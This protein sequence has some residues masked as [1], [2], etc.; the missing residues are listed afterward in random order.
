M[1]KPQR[2]IT[3]KEVAIDPSDPLQNTEISVDAPVSR[4]EHYRL[5]GSVEEMR[6]MM[7]QF[8]D[9][10]AAFREQQK[11]LEKQRQMEEDAVEARRVQDDDVQEDEVEE[12][13]EEDLEKQKEIALLKSLMQKYGAEFTTHSSQKIDG[14]THST[15]IRMSKDKSEGPTASKETD[16]VLTKEDI[17][18][19]V[20]EENQHKA[21]EGTANEILTSTVKK[22]LERITQSPFSPEI[23]MTPSPKKFHQPSFEGYTG[24]GDPGVHL[25]QYQQKMTL[26]SDNEAFLCKLFPASLKGQA[27]TWFYSLKKNSIKS[28]NDLKTCFVNQYIH[29]VDKE[30]GLESLMTIKQEPKESLKDYVARFKK[31][32]NRV[33]SAQENQKMTVFALKQGLRIGE[34][35]HRRFVRKNPP[36]IADAYRILQKEVDA[37]EEMKATMH[38]QNRLQNPVKEEK[39]AEEQRNNKKARF[40]KPNEFNPN[41]NNYS[42]YNSKVHATDPGQTQIKQVYGAA[43]AT[44]K[45]KEREGRR[46]R[47]VKPGEKVLTKRYEDIFD[48]IKDEPYL[49]YPKRPYTD[50]PAAHFCK[51][52]G[53]RC[54][55]TENCWHLTDEIQRLVKQGMLAHL[56]AEDQG[57]EDEQQVITLPQPPNPM[58][59]INM[60]I[61]GKRVGTKNERR[62]G[63]RQI[64]LVNQSMNFQEV[65]Q[66]APPRPADDDMSAIW[67]SA[68]DTKRLAS[69]HWDALVVTMVIANNYIK[70]TLVDGGSST[71][72]MSWSCFEALGFTD[73]DL[74]PARFSLFAFNDTITQSLGDITLP[75]V[76]GPVTKMI[77]FVVADFNSSYNVILGRGWIHEMKAVP[78]TYH[79]VI[80]FP[81]DKGL[82]ELRGNQ[83][84]SQKCME[85]ATRNVSNIGNTPKMEDVQQGKRPIV[86]EELVDLSKERKKA[87][88]HYSKEKENFISGSKEGAS[89][90]P[91]VN[92][93]AVAAPVT[94]ITLVGDQNQIEKND[95]SARTVEEKTSEAVEAIQLGSPGENKVTYIGTA[96]PQE[97]KDK[98]VKVLKDNV[99]SFAFSMNE[100]DGIPEYFAC[101]KLDLIQGSKPVKQRPRRL[102]PKLSSGVL[103]EIHRL[104]QAG[105]IR[106]VQ[107]SDWL[108]NMVVVPKKNGKLRVC[109]D[110]TDLNKAC[111]KDDYIMP[112][113][114]DLV[115]RTAGFELLSFM[116]GYAGYNQ[117]PMRESDEV[118]TS[119]IT[120]IG[121]FCYKRMP[122]GLKNAGATYQKLVDTMFRDRIQKNMEV[123]IDDM[124]VKSVTEDEHITDLQET[125]KTLKQYGMKLNPEKCA[126]GVSSGKFLGFL[127]SKR[128]IEACPTQIRALVE[129]PSPR[130]KKQVQKLVGMLNAL[131]RFISKSSDRCRPIF[132]LLKAQVQF[133]WSD[134][135][136]EAFQQLKQYL[137]SVPILSKAEDGEEL[138]L[139]LAVTDVAISSVL[140]RLHEGVEK[141]VYFLSKTLLDAE[142]RYSHLEK[143]AL[144]LVYS[145]QRLRPYFQ[146]CKITVVTSFPL[147]NIIERADKSS[148]MEKWAAI[149]A[150]HSLHYKPRTAIKAQAIADFLVDFPVDDQFWKEDPEVL[151]TAEE[152]EQMPDPTDPI[153]GWRLFTDGS[154]GG[155]GCGIGAIL[156]NDDNNRLELAAKLGFHATNNAT[157]YE[158]LIAGLDMAIALGVKELIVYMDSLLV[159]NQV[160]GGYCAR[161]DSMAAYLAV[162]LSKKAYFRQLRLFHIPRSENRHADAL[163]FVAAM[164][165]GS[166][167]RKI[168]IGFIETPTNQVEQISSIQSIPTPDTWMTPFYNFLQHGTLPESKTKA[169]SLK[170]RVRKYSIVDNKLYRRSSLGGVLLRCVTESE[171]ELL[172]SEIH[173]GDCGNHASGK[174]LARKI[175][176]Q[177]YYWPKMADSAV[178]YV[179]RCHKCQIHG[180][181]IHVPAGPLNNIDSPYPFAIWGVDIVGRLTKTP[182][183][184]EYMLAFT[185]YFTKWV[186]AIAL[187]E[188]K[189]KNVTD[190]I[191]DV[192]LIRFG[193][194]YAIIADNGPQ[195]DS[196]AIKKFCDTKGIKL[197]HS[198]AYY[199][200]CNGQA[201]STN[202]TIMANIRKKLDKKKGNWAKILPSVLWAY[203]TT[204]RTATGESPFAMTYGVEAVLPIEARIHTMRTKAVETDQNTE[205]QHFDLDT[206]EGRR[207]KARMK[208]EQYRQTWKKSYNKKVRNRRFIVGELVLKK[209]FSTTNERNAG[210]FKANWEGPFVIREV[211][212]A[213][214]YTLDTIDG[215][216]VK[217]NCN[218]LHLKKYYQ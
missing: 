157:E 35:P 59:T 124:L 172:M 150:Q 183:K 129:M 153:N 120:E 169:R 22:T 68:S 171:I 167:S 116:D 1:P 189:T 76:T 83:A 7:R 143:L 188:V 80:R 8:L 203:R 140:I 24:A 128:G 159:V 98:I 40:Q 72:L 44:Q 110:F 149:L 84:A 176:K 190:F 130:T 162:V 30:E 18:A 28:W 138:F 94:D 166:E 34:E 32:S 208:L 73:K 96:L 55:H 199:P 31:L 14:S 79:Q 125:F 204:P 184:E 53:V 3:S 137:G 123:Y 19:L 206:V 38:V 158:A 87:R 136:E 37:I 27:L 85:I 213:G 42:D 114:D 151:I 118:K 210:K 88:V 197:I 152:P 10:Q 218:I 61:I 216:E 126:F 91:R 127:V 45:P 56:I 121:T 163:A 33:P 174:S 20:K 168:D 47:T 179:K 26:W 109:I 122:F 46:E 2:V 200:Q 16:T 148:R 39:Q 99:N 139:Y 23:L 58:R 106:P 134:D 135:C 75:V 89:S 86:V 180:P 62:E 131:G 48:M 4:E 170:E 81:T 202:K 6:N 60:I 215:K 92:A 11:E 17:L 154:S 13:S 141:P 132:N 69:P 113:V 194:P 51:F 100:M 82:Y 43:A 155:H 5:A 181:D 21:E 104:Q 212:L 205:L 145:A 142:T 160:N 64:N 147:K 67:F 191:Q 201:E 103:E 196:V 146:A 185:D 90:N 186:E 119:F 144:A 115:M 63:I 193:T 165:N 156:V 93:V 36:T 209:Q 66:P 198:A 173:D 133:E 108:S 97:Q 217:Y 52:H 102:N 187:P 15:P 57:K 161:T 112:R 41:Y 117:I 101:H 192:I 107:Y 77:K 74:E 195:F 95:S 49:K 214:N 65:A 70:R 175:W 71:D 207:D 105:I 50:N 177:G 25:M 9:E 182:Q 164:L 211:G 178:E 29:M 12:L 54:H 111:P 78:S